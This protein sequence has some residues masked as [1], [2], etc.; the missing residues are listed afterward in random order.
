MLSMSGSIRVAFELVEN[1]IAP[2]GRLHLSDEAVIPFECACD[3]EEHAAGI[4]VEV[5]A[6]I[7]NEQ[8]EQRTRDEEDSNAVREA[9]SLHWN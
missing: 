5:T 3:V 7:R 1:F 9:E 8:E 6:A 2:I 4:A